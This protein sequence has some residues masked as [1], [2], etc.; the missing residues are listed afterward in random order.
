MLCFL[1]LRCF[2]HLLQRTPVGFNHWVS[3]QFRHWIP[4]NSIIFSPMLKFCNNSSLSV[5]SLPWSYLPSIN[6]FSCWYQHQ[7][8]V[9]PGSPGE[10]VGL[11]GHYSPGC[12]SL[13][14]HLGDSL[15][16]DEVNSS[17]NII[18]ESKLYDWVCAG[19]IVAVLA[20]WNGYEMVSIITLAVY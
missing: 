8:D 14:I 18:E 1:K 12:H 10:E 19:G 20:G 2:F 6:A 16:W 7:P 5:S 9:C 4:L 11:P 13:P 17:A 15:L 3:Q